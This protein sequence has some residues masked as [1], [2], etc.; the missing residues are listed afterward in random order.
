[1]KIDDNKIADRE[2]YLTRMQQSVLD[3][4]FFIDKVFEPF[5]CNRPP[6]V[7]SFFRQDYYICNP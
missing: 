3:K 5:S 6:R 4:I 7:L 2:I 1:M